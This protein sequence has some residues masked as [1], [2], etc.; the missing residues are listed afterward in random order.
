MCGG[1]GL[2]LLAVVLPGLGLG[3]LGP[4]GRAEAARA[5]GGE[6]LVADLKNQ[7]KL[8]SP[9]S[10]L[11]CFS[12]FT[13]KKEGPWKLAKVEPTSDARAEIQPRWQTTNTS[14]WQQCI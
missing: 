1:L 3:V 2:G 13:L 4:G 12:F 7:E 8:L 10:L 6:L 11:H 5:V 9:S 14:T